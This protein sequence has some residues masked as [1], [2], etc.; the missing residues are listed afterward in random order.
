MKVCILGNNLTSLSLAK[1]LINQGIFVDIFSDDKKKVNYQKSRTIG[2]SKSNLSFF[3]KNI[4]DI[5]KIT[6]KINKIEIY[7]QNLD[8]KKILDF[9]DNGSELFSIFKNYELIDYLTTELS[10]DKL[11]KFKKK[12]SYNELKKKDYKLIFNCDVNHQIT[13][14]FF[15]KKIDKNYDSYAYTTVIKHKKK[16]NNNTAKQIFT[17]LGPLAFLPISDV[18]TSVVYS[19]KGQKNIELKDVIKKYNSYYDV[20]KIEEPSKLKLRSS[21]LRTYYY[22]NVLA[23][24][25]L[26]HRLHPLA[27]QGFNMTIRDIEE[28]LEIIE[29]KTNLGLDINNQVCQEFEKRMRHKNYLFSY[30]IDFI[31]EFF[32]L[33]NKTL[34]NTV[35]FFGKNKTINKLFS[36]IADNG[37]KF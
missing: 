24:G 17:F 12:L 6:W 14:K 4:L 30:G 7:S 1:T 35:K 11:F 37:I 10:N 33:E 9:E 25:D 31:H 32:N 26:L 5:E 3:N 18:E 21:S 8:D 13:K 20:V 29:S 28:L 36:S 34:I 19:V 23:F 15:Y 2:I 16:L 27:G 22:Q